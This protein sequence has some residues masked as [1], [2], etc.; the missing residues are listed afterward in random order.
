MDGSKMEDKPFVGFASIDIKDGRSM[1]LRISE[2][3]FTFTAEALAIGETLEIIE[4]LDS[5]Q[6]V[7]IF[8]DSA[9]VLKR[10][11]NSSTMNSTSH[12]A[13]MRKD[14]IRRMES[15]GKIIQFYRIPGHC[16]V[17][18]NERADS[19]AKQA[20]KEGRYNQLLLPVADLKKQW[21]KKAKNFTVF[22]ETPNGTEEKDTLKGTGGMARLRG[23]ARSK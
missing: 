18:V 23:S 7:M 6:N 20:I 9:S 16:G 10:I 22:V 3:A 8:S 12:I 14:K 19:E 13:Q 21:K 15:R 5:E 11:I 17:E 1:K 2:I 4:K